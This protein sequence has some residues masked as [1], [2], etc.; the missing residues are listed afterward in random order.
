MNLQRPNANDMN[1]TRNRSRDI[2]PSSVYAHV[3]LMII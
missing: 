3:V 2:S 1:E